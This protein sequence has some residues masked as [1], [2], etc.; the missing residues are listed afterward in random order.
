VLTQG[1]DRRV[2]ELDLDALESYFRLQSPVMPPT[3]NRIT[4]VAT[5]AR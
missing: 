1:Q 5:V 3:T 4:R 2:G